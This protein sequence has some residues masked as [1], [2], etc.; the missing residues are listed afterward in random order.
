MTA[1]L[2]AALPAVLGGFLF[3]R[4]FYLT[5]FYIARTQGQRLFFYAASLGIIFAFI[6][7]AW[8]EL[9]FF[10]IERLESSWRTLGMPP[11]VSQAIAPFLLAIFLLGTG[12]LLVHARRVHSGS[13]EQTANWADLML[14][15]K[16]RVGHEIESFLLVSAHDGKPVMVSLEDRKVYVGILAGVINRTIDSDS[17]LSIFPDMSGYR[18]PTTNQITYTTDY[19][20]FTYHNLLQWKHEI[21]GELQSEDLDIDSEIEPKELKELN[22]QISGEIELM[23]ESHFALDADF[24]PRDWVKYIP[25]ERIVSIGPYDVDPELFVQLEDGSTSPSDN[26]SSGETG[27]QV[28]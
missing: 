14:A 2:L 4:F 21:E 19:A 28:S 27:T 3:L 8:I 6:S 24:D 17:W 7:I 25:T 26:T 18:H 11:G 16:G 15:R 5:R 1:K 20:P 13:K 10:P 12:N 22:D 23:Q 9:R